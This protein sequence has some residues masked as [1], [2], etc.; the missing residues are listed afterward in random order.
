MDQTNSLTCSLVC[1]ACGSLVNV[2]VGGKCTM[3]E[4]G[5]VQMPPASALNFDQAVRTVTARSRREVGGVVCEEEV[6][7]PM[8]LF[9]TAEEALARAH[10]VLDRR[11]KEK[12]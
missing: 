12:A 1:G 10:A 5:M 4:Y 8:E 2:L 11:M 9:E 3:C 6:T 7:I